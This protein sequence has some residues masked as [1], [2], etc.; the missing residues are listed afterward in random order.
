MTKLSIDDR[1][2][3]INLR[4]QG[5]S[6]KQIITEHYPNITRQTVSSVLKKAKEMEEYDFKKLLKEGNEQ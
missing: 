6:V 1:N 3:I 5:I 4:N 2:K